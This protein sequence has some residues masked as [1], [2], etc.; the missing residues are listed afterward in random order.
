M[1]GIFSRLCRSGGSKKSKVRRCLRKGT[2][3]L[4]KGVESQD[5]GCG[6][7]IISDR[8]EDETDCGHERLGCHEWGVGA[9]FGLQR[10]APPKLR[11]AL[12]F[13]MQIYSA[14]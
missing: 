11:E 10:S 14:Y 8:P 13:H 12:S 3:G 5:C 7:G 4:S 2:A 1:R 6:T 9:G